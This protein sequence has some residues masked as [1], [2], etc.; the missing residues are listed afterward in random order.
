[1]V[2]VCAFS[3]QFLCACVRVCVCMSART[4]AVRGTC[5]HASVCAYVH[6][7]YVRV[8]VYVGKTIIHIDK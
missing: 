6:Y 8:H 4:S 3:V 2:N 5:L 7:V 1:M